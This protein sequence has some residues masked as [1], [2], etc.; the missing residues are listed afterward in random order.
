MEYP[1]IENSPHKSSN[2][3]ADTV[4]RFRVAEPQRGADA[5]MKQDFVTFYSPGSFVSECRTEPIDSWDVG[6]AMELAH[7]IIERHGARPYG[8][9]FTTRS[10]NDND[11]DSS[12]TATSPFYFL[13]GKVETLEEVKMRATERDR[14]LITNMECNGWTHI[15]TNNNSW[16]FTAPLKDSDIVLDWAHGDAQRKGNGIS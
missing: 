4:K 1:K 9:Q 13:G 15:I 7:S 8:F 11:L 16:S 5:T 10:S 3:N 2:P 6:I 14:I 12:V